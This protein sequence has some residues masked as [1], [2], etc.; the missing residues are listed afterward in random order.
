MAVKVKHHKG[1]WW[2]FIDHR[3]KRKA[4][5]IGS[6]SAAEAVAKKIE[7]KIALGQFEIAEEKERMPFRSYYKTWLESYVRTHTKA[8][9]YANYETAYRVHLLP[10]FGET[11]IRAI[12]REQLKR[13]IYEKLNAGLSRNSV[14]GYLAPLSEMF[15]HAIEDGHL[16]RNPCL[17]IMRTTRKEK[18]EQQGKIDFLTREEVALLL[19]TY[20]E[21]CPAYY[22]F[23]LLLART[24]LRLGEAVALQWGDIDFHT[25]F[26]DV[27]RNWV[28][29]T[30][31]TPKSGKARR[32]DMS[33]HLTETL[34]ALLIARKKETLKQGWGEV[35]PWV[36]TS[37][38][39][40]MMDPDNFRRRVWPK[41]LT[42]A[43]LR[44]IRIH[45][46]R[47][48]FASLLLQQGAPVAYVKEQLGHA[49]IRMTV[50]VYGHLVPGGNRSEVDRLDGPETATI[51]NLSATTPE[52][53]VLPKRLSP[54]ID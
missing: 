47:H 5:A 21:H 25:R 26:I 41:L 18:G 27:R 51:R 32:V 20:R 46:L 7:A 4:K 37:A 24:G 19:D 44:Q 29:G 36:F 1:A 38:A 48:T 8:S 12:T 10:C 34:R 3:G 33:T 45:D 49:S 6:K 16:E 53:A 35:P 54:R 14:K 52:N 43:G 28:D 50:D 9:T 22:P 31:T 42:K 39:G 15:N 40:T 2:V 11:D 13:F 30:L 23:V 17:R